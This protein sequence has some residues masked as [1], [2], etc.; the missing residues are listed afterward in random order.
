[1][2]HHSH[3]FRFLA[4][5]ATIAFG[6]LNS[7]PTDAQ[8]Q[9]YPCET[10]MQFGTGM[11]AGGAKL[12]P[13]SLDP[14]FEGTSA[15]FP[16]RPDVYVVTDPPAAWTDNASSADSQ[17]IGPSPSV[18]DDAAGTY[19]Y[20]L[21]FTT[22]CAGARVMGRYSAGDRGALRLNGAAAV[23]FP[24]PATGYNVWTAFSFANLPAGANTIEFYVTNAPTAVGPPGPTGLRA[25]LTVTATCCPCIVL[26]C[27][28]DI[29]LTTCTTGATANFSI[30]GTNR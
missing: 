8:T 13:G 19:V 28:P 14:F 22:P 29:F 3:P 26:T 17:W 30:T 25:E 16:D 12:R 6:L 27:P 11:S 23:S 2:N 18:A 4:G 20:R 24:T 15:N 21:Q 7:S 10:V 5:A 1:M 9:T